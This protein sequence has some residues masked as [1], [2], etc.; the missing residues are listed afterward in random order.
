M[1]TTVGQPERAQPPSA[2]L[3][4]RTKFLQRRGLEW[5]TGMPLYSYRVSK[6]EF[7]ELES[8]L[9]ERLGA[10]LKLYSLG[11]IA[12]LVTCFP[13][14][15]VLYAAEWWRRRYD[16]TGWSWE[17]IV[18]GLGAPPSGWSQAQ[19]SHC[20]ERGL[21]EWR[22]GLRDTH[23]LR[24]LGSIAFNGGLPMQ[25]LATAR[26]N[27]GRVLTRVLRLAAG[28]SADPSDIQRWIESL[29]SYL[30][31]AYRQQEIYVL[32][33]EVV[34][35]VIRLRASA[36]L[37]AAAGAIAELDRRDPHW[38]NLFPFPVEDEQAQGLLEQLVKDA[39]TVRPVRSAAR[40]TLDRSLEQS[41]DGSWQ[42]R[43]ELQL[44]EYFSTAELAALFSAEASALPRALSLLVERGSSPVEML[45]RRLAGQERYRIDRRPVESRHRDASS[46]HSLALYAPD[47]AAWRASVAR[48]ES[49]ETDIP[50]IFDASDTDTRTLTLVR[51]GSGAISSR[52]CWVCVPG[53][54]QHQ[55]DEEGTCVPVGVLPT[56]DR[57]VIHVSGGARFDDSTG[58]TYRIRTG[59]A[60]AIEE[61]L[62]W[63]GERV[64]DT[65]ASP[66]VAFRGIP[67][68]YRIS[69]E[70]LAQQASGHIG[71]R[72]PGG[73]ATL[74]PSGLFG[75]LEATWP[76]GG[77]VRLRS[78]LVV[79]PAGSSEAL[80]PGKSPSEGLIRLVNWGALS[81]RARSEGI[82]CV[83][84][85]AGSSLVA[86]LSWQGS[87]SPP[88]WVDLD[89]YWEGNPQHAVV[90]FPFPALGAKAFD[91][92]G[93]Q[94]LNGA[95][96]SIDKLAGVRLVAFLGKTSRAQLELRTSDGTGSSGRL[97]VL[98]EIKA[99]AGSNR[100]EV[101][102]IDYLAEIQRMLAN[103]DALDATIA[104][105]LRPTGA[106]GVSVGVS[107]Y[108]AA[109]QRDLA[110]NS[111]MLEP[112][113]ATRL[114]PDELARVQLCALRLDQPGEEPLSIPQAESEGVPTASWRFDCDHPAPGPWLIFPSA[115]SELKSRPLLWPI[116]GNGEA[117]EGLAHA[118]RI[119]D[120]SQRDAALDL[121]IDTLS[122]DLTHPDWTAIE[123][124]AGHLSHLPLSSL[125]LWRRFA[126][127]Y[128]G[129]A[130]LVFRVGALPTGMVARFATELPFLWELVPFHSWR[131]A[132]ALV[133]RQCNDWYGSETGPTMFDGHIE[134]RIQELASSDHSLRVL[135]ESA[136]DSVT[137]IVSKDVNLARQPMMDYIF[138]G[139]LFHGD[140]CRLQQLL[141]SNAESQWPGGFTAEVSAARRSFG[142]APYMCPV[143]HGFHDNVI[144]LPVLLAI[145]AVTGEGPDWLSRPDAIAMLRAHQA[146]DPDW[147]AEAFDLTVA[148]CLSTGLLKIEGFEE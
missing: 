1:T 39:A 52:E 109:M 148:R 63:R 86:D 124:L 7:T 42:L 20:V 14:L 25:L 26:G 139:Q 72:S 119:S 120:R 6:E 115:Q 84:S 12:R 53:T 34:L 37:T 43:A 85:R 90:R 23:G 33:A 125:D 110:S 15:F 21:A 78:R 11:D 132:I 44:P 102:L 4:W 36:N 129:T 143:D 128:S 144:N 57:V 40:I 83:S 130:A 141:R 101:R 16:G 126:R 67:R 68:L 65:F 2:L 142:A 3:Q 32:L 146:F 22:L 89:V 93:C 114:S 46:V 31:N 29:A 73:R 122:A 95:R 56:L 28:G 24:F 87:G 135:L 41:E 92:A 97:S 107:R 88:E 71:W 18:E 77:D 136:R 50:W 66:P 106:S 45:L 59:H 103:S 113:A 131:K 9:T 17:P 13:P 58:Q 134:R 108:A 105:A 138:A 121:V 48:G 82:A 80:E 8:L 112:A 51:Q 60:A 96:L 64:W 54:W 62:E 111:V 104:V 79:L 5:P 10:Y 116:E 81:L 99:P 98:R 118:L 140:E 137:G 74:T 94:L 38:R 145:Q 123:R 117:A 76:V 35:T 61:Q 133:R 127:S 100:A 30:P 147:F 49:L 19:R 47:G 55:A 27:I 70:G 75:P 69:D 91:A